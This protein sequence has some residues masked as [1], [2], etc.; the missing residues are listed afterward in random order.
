MQQE[1]T[2]LCKDESMAEVSLGGDRK[3]RVGWKRDTL[4]RDA[5]KRADSAVCGR[6]ISCSCGQKWWRTE[7]ELRRGESFDD[8]HGPPALGTA[9]RNAQRW[10]VTVPGVSLPMVKSWAWYS[11]MCRGPRRSGEQ[12]KCWAKRSMKRM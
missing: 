11:R 7:L 8:G 3:K 4:R 6:V 2:A 1:P 10:L 9:P 5:L 12:W